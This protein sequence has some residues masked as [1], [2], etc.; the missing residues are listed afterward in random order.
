LHEIHSL[1]GKTT[2]SYGQN[3]KEKIVLTRGRISHSKLTHIYILYNE[4]RS[5]CIPCNSINVFRAICHEFKISKILL[6]KCLLLVTLFILIFIQ[7][8][9]IISDAD[10]SYVY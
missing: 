2:C 4:E 5:E 6:K 3:R 10:L 9:F 1:V 7:H 8:L